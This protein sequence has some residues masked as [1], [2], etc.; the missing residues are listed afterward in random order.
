[1]LV[2]AHKD[3]LAANDEKDAKIQKLQAKIPHCLASVAKPKAKSHIIPKSARKVA[4]HSDDED[5]EDDNN[6][7]GAL[8]TPG[9]KLKAHN[10]KRRVPPKSAPKQRSRAVEPSVPRHDFLA[11]DMVLLKPAAANL[12]KAA[13]GRILEDNPS[14]EWMKIELHKTD[15]TL[16][17]KR[18]KYT[19]LAGLDDENADE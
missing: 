4:I 13:K 15:G 19:S 7:I 10:T 16:V 8:K 3:V 14:D 2:G 12:H 5:D 6:D 11:G 9:G 18:I 17:T 1:M